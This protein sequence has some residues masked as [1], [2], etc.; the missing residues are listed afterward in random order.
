[1]FVKCPLY[2]NQGP[3][4]S[5]YISPQILVLNQLC[6]HSSRDMVRRALAPHPHQH[7]QRRQL[8]PAP[9]L[10]ARPKRTPKRRQ[11]LQ[12]LRVRPYHHLRLRLRL[13][14]RGGVVPRLP[15]GEARGGEVLAAR[16]REAEGPPGGE[17]EGVGHGV[18]G[19]LAGEGHGGDDGGRG[20][21]VHGELV[22]VVAR[23]EVAVEGGEDRWV[24]L[25]RGAMGAWGE[26]SPFSSPFLSSRF[27]CMLLVH[28]IY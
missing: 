24:V 5:L 26:G 25:V 20:E 8:Q 13:G 11:Q 1:M 22:A 6:T 10:R 12:P 27:H 4:E 21:E 3:Y 7:L 2:F 28:R 16:G 15:G 18:E 17:R 14:R 19:E 23:L 9:I